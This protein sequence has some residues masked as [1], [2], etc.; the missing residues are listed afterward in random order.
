MRCEVTLR[1]SERGVAW[2]W[3]VVQG[4]RDE[5]VG[6]DEGQVPWARVDA[7]SGVVRAAARAFESAQRA[8]ENGDDLDV[9]D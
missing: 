9:G 8:V 3:S 1:P 4:E 6:A 2:D 7:L 5:E